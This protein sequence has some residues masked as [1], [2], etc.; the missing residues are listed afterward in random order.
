VLALSVANSASADPINYY[1]NFQGA[2]G[3]TYAGASSLTGN[4]VTLTTVGSTFTGAGFYATNALSFDPTL[5]FQS[6]F[7]FNI[8]AQS[9]GL[10]G[11]GFTFVLTSNPSTLGTSSTNLGLGATPGTP[12]VEVQFST[13]ANSTNNPTFAPGQYYS[14]LVA[15]STD[16]N[17]VIP[18][19]SNSYAA[20]YGV[21]QCD[22]QTNTK[23][24]RAGCLANG[25][26]WQAAI[27]YQ[28]GLLSVALCDPKEAGGTCTSGSYVTVLAGYAINLASILGGGPIYAGFTASNGAVTETVQID[29]WQLSAVPEPASL[30]ALG[31]GIAA[32]GLVR[33]KR[34]AA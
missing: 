30:A 11:N 27:A 32:L 4:N 33:W 7:S 28:N 29:S 10:A 25:D 21:N 31:A 20:P 15:V 3:L 19:N 14:N 6:D 24:S 34:R 5:N 1:P 22:N 12:S 2:T 8:N 16:G 9:S 17:V 18:Q 23:S 13:F 26:V